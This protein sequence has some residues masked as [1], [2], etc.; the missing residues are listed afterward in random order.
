MNHLVMV[1][2]KPVQQPGDLQEVFIYLGVRSKLTLIHLTENDTQI[3]MITYECIKRKSAI[4]IECLLWHFNTF[5][6]YW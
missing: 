4:R 2:R 6:S 3:R 1:Q 5:V